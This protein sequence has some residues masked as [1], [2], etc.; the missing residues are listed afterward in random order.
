ML[1]HSLD[2]LSLASEF[3]GRDPQRIFVFGKLFEK[4]LPQVPTI[5]A[6]EWDEDM[7][8]HGD[9]RQFTSSVLLTQSRFPGSSGLPS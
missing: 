1:L 3:N 5:W 6:L 8:D 2:P 9:F 4:S 7:Q